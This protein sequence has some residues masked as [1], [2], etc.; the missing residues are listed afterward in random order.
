M[1]NSP[2]EICGTSSLPSCG[3]ISIVSRNSASAPPRTLM[4]CVQRPADRRRVE[5]LAEQV[6]RLRCI[7][8]G[9][10]QP[11]HRS[12]DRS[13]SAPQQRRL[14]STG[15]AETRP[16][17]LPRRVRLTSVAT[18]GVAARREHRHQRQRHC[19]R[20]QQ[21]VGHRQRLVLEQLARDA[22]DEHH[23][24]EHGD[25]SQRRGGHG[26]RDFARAQT[27]PPPLASGRARACARS[28]RARRPRCRPAC[29]RRAP[30]RRAT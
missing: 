2:C 16:S 14:P 4:R 26:R 25:R 6:E 17:G 23:R 21:R 10:E 28:P 29:R 30:G 7:H 13:R 15:R 9:A 5:S 22:G 18:R 1:L 11:L 27:A 3:T 19:Q 8:G 24:E 20:Q 12:R